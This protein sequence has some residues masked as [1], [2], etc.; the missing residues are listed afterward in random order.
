MRRDEN[1]IY[2]TLAIAMLYAAADKLGGIRS[3]LLSVIILRGNHCHF[4]FIIIITDTFLP[5]TLLP[6]LLFIFFIINILYAIIFHII[7]INNQ[8]EKNI[9]IKIIKK[10]ELALAMMIIEN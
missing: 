5:F 3:L 1:L 10:K 2:Q 4:N 7:I 9:K 6:P 8:R